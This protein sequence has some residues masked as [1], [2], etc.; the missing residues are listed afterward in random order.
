[1]TELMS[2]LYSFVTTHKVNGAWDDPEYRE[3]CSCA[4]RQEKRLRDMLDGD[5]LQVLDDM[6]QEQTL[7]HCIELELLFQGTVAL[8]RDL[9]RTL[10]L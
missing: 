4:Q 7:Q 5:A 1:M 9:N 2:D 10:L 3:S 8:C 6:I